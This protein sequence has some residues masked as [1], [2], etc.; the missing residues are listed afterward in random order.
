ME[1]SSDLTGYC[2]KCKSKE[3]LKNP[4]VKTNKRGGK[5]IQAECIKCNTKVNNFLKNNVSIR[6]N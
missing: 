1:S 3:T 2:L 6:V 4:S 5:Y